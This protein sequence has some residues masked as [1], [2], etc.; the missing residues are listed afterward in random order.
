VDIT[1]GDFA[2]PRTIGL[3]Q[4][5]GAAK[6]KLELHLM[7]RRPQDALGTAIAL[8]PDLIIIHAEADCD[9]IAVLAEL[10]RMGVRA[11]LA[12][13]PDTSI[14]SVRDLLPTADHLLIFTGSQLG[15]HSREFLPENLTKIAAARAV[16]P[17]LEIGVDGSI[18]L[19]N[20]AQAAVAG[21]DVLYVGG[22]IRRAPDPAAAYYALVAAANG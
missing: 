2:D 20:A 1:D 10:Q 6:A 13:L 4:V 18:N 8:H 22:A 15:G 16:N 9:H 21:A 14:D 19:T 11:G 3:G 17:A 5:Y 12:V 7:L